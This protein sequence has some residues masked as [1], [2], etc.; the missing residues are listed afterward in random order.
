MALFCTDVVRYIY[1]HCKT[2]TLIICRL[3]CKQWNN[4]YESIFAEYST[5]ARLLLNAHHMDIVVRD[6]DVFLCNNLIYKVQ[7]TPPHLRLYKTVDA[8]YT[9]CVLVPLRR[10]DTF[11]SAREKISSKCI[12]YSMNNND[13]AIWSTGATSTVLR[14]K[15]CKADIVEHGNDSL[16]LGSGLVEHMMSPH[17]LVMCPT[18]LAKW[19][20]IHKNVIYHEDDC[21]YLLQQMLGAL[22]T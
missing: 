18:V 1:A 16:G 11:E 10:Y 3:V 4:I 19:G 2:I 15:L 22:Y 13:L 21:A 9:I 6:N 8:A 20:A 12:R 17:K 5:R 14:C 7:I